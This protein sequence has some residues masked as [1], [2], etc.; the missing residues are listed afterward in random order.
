MSMLNSCH[1][2]PKLYRKC[3]TSER[4]VASFVCP[5]ANYKLGRNG[6][7]IAASERIKYGQLGLPDR[8]EYCMMSDKAPVMF[9]RLDGEEHDV[10]VLRALRRVCKLAL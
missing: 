1:R 6:I 10:R 4:G 2:A 5:C 9:E 7:S 8:V 3:A